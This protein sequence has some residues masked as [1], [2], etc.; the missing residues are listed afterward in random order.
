MVVA[1]GIG[2]PLHVHAEDDGL[3]ATPECGEGRT[4]WPPIQRCVTPPVVRTQSQPEYGD[5][6][7]GLDYGALLYL[8]VTSKGGVAD[9]QIIKAPLEG[10][11]TP[12]GEAIL[13]AFV[14]S[15]RHWTFD[16]GVDAEGRPLAMT[17]LLKI[18]L[19]T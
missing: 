15:V 5:A 7:A 13:S 9:V 1:F 8:H 14:R 6:P 17:V 19:R 12:E 10:E 2:F 4:W 11:E 18:R 3:P 16:P